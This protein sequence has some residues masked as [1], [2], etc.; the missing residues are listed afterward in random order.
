MILQ[1]RADC[2]MADNGIWICCVSSGSG[3]ET[4]LLYHYFLP[5]GT[6]W[7]PS[8]MKKIIRRKETNVRR[9]ELV[10]INCITALDYDGNVLK[11]IAGFYRCTG[12]YIYCVFFF[13]GQHIQVKQTWLRYC[14]LRFQQCYGFV[15]RNCYNLEEGY[16]IAK[17]HA[18][19]SCYIV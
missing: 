16:Y 17:L 2:L 13:Q 19:R 4:I 11:E 5:R 12:Y 8:G 18:T 14:V 9:L 6:I 15:L 3:K 10:N 1:K 7:C